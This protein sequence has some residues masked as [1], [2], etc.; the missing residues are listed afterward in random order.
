MPARLMER[1]R[2]NSR[3]L[4]RCTT[5]LA[6]W[7]SSR[8]FS[9]RL[10]DRGTRLFGTTGAET[11]RGRGLTPIPPEARMNADWRT[12]YALAVEAARR[13]GDLA[14]TYYETTFEVE[15]KHDASPV[16]VQCLNTR[17]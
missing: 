16:T 5:V 9:N 11:G 4:R 10:D 12:R 13:A 14:R 8:L 3:S 17:G 1:P 15:L 6:R 7:K 2:F